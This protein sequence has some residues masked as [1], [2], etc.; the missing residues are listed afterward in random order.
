MVDEPLGEL[1]RAG[2]LPQVAL[3]VRERALEADGDARRRPQ[4][5]GK[6]E[7]DEPDRAVGHQ[8]AAGQEGQEP[9]VDHDHGRD[10]D[11]EEHRAKTLRAL[12]LVGVVALYSWSAAALAPFTTSATVAVVGGGVAAMLVAAALP[13]SRRAAVPTPGRPGLWLVLVAAT[14]LWELA[15]YLQ[16]PRHDHPTLSSLANAALEG[17]PVRAAALLAWLSLGI[18]FARR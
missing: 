18:V 17:R 3:E 12:P 13:R 11:V 15:A 7:P 9:E 14:A 1:G 4:H 10:G 8:A 6:M 2:Q 16:H 5:D